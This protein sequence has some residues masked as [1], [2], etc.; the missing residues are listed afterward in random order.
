MLQEIQAC[1]PCDRPRVLGLTASP[2][3]VE[4]FIKGRNQLEKFRKTFV[5]ASFFYPS[6]ENSKNEATQ[7]TINRSKEQNQFIEDVIGLI[8]L[9]V[10]SVNK[11]FKGYCNSSAI[12]HSS[13]LH[14]KGDI[15]A[16]LGE[17]P[18]S[19]RLQVF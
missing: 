7:V 5:N 18:E 14:L 1:S 9:C 10:N 3:K 19:K 16:L 12:K 17:Y 11:F 13:L 15:R 6:I 8:K 4:N 2:F